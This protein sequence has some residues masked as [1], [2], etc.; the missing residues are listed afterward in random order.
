[1]AVI[2]F[3]PGHYLDAETG[4]QYLRARYYDPA[5][6][7]FL[8]RDLL[9]RLTRSPYGYVHGNPL[10]GSDPSGL[11]G[12]LPPSVSGPYIPCEQYLQGVTAHSQALLNTISQLFRPEDA[13]LGGS[14]AELRREAAEAGFD[15]AG[16][17]V[18]YTKVCERI[19]NLNNLLRR[20]SLDENDQAI[21]ENL[22]ED[23]QSA[24]AYADGAIANTQAAA[25][26]AATVAS[27]DPSLL[28]EIG[29]DIEAGGEDVGALLEEGG[30]EFGPFL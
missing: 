24:K 25:T 10:N 8:S 1:V 11:C 18:H 17:G 12:P 29:D 3:L 6:G 2:P 30:E 22:L 4:F 26:A 27:Q 5:T 23:L 16:A 15:P 19:N 13:R 28:Q 14:A 20:G 7:Q 9:S 21:A